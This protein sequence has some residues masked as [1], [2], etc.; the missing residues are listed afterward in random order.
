MFDF[1]YKLHSLEVA[2]ITLVIGVLVAVV[3]RRMTGVRPSGVLGTAI[4]LLAAADSLYWAAVLLIIAP[5]ISYLYGKF[6]SHKFKG[7]EPMYVLSAMAIVMATIGGLILQALHVFPISSLSFPLGII[8]PA[9]TASIISR[10]GVYQTYRHLAL[11]VVITLEIVILIYGIGRFF[12][13]DFLVLDR[14]VQPRQTLELSWSALFA[15]FSVIV[16]FFTYRRFKVKAVGFITLPPL[17]TILIVSPINFLLLIGTAVVVYLLAAV[18][19]RFSLVVGADRFALVTIVSVAVVWTVT[20]LLVHHTSSFSP[21][22]GTG[23]FAAVVASVLVNEHTRYGVRKA[24]PP[25]VISLTAMIAVQICVS[26]TLSLFNSN[27]TNLHYYIVRQA[28]QQK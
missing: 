24:F 22:L 9:I 7:R 8:F 26:F 10:Q 15:L 5:I 1:L 12:N 21:Y 2:S 3:V 19:R 18:L 17:A 20:Y 23:M 14:M 16:G 6:F 13:Y 11:A 27:S 4:I 28:T 25:F